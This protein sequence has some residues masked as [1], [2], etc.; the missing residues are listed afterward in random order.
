MNFSHP[1]ISIFFL[2]KV[3]MRFATFLHYPKRL[4]F[5]KY[6]VLCHWISLI[7]MTKSA[8]KLIWM[9]KTLKICDLRAQCKK[10]FGYGSRPPIFQSLKGSDTFARDAF[11]PMFLTWL[12]LCFDT[13]APMC[14]HLCPY[15]LTPLPLSFDTFALFYL[16]LFFK[17][18]PSLHQT[19]TSLSDLHLL[20]F[21]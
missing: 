19:P 12:P 17:H 15:V 5:I 8:N 1:P 9:V 18:L 13:F 4:D 6:E 21:D 11:A 2:Q 14:I 3:C 20:N 10:F 16:F 7:W